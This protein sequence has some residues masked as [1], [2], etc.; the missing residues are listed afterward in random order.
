MSSLHEEFVSITGA[1]LD[2]ALTWLE[3]GQYDLQNAVELFLSS[4]QNQTNTD[5]QNQNY[6]PKLNEF[7]DNDVVRMPDSVKRGRLMDETFM[8][9]SESSPKELTLFF[10]KYTN[11][12]QIKRQDQLLNLH[13]HLDLDLS[14]KMR[15]KGLLLISTSHQWT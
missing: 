12:C 8:I 1:S 3:I 10:I 9:S 7:V 5:H 4:N 13:L 15:K 14:L 11:S 6:V 2:D